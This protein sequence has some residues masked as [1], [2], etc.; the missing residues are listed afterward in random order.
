MKIIVRPV[1][2]PRR[3]TDLT[4]RLVSAIAE[5]L[6]SLQGGNRQLNWLEAECHLQW[7]GG[8]ARAEVD[9][10]TFVSLGAA[11][12]AGD[13][14]EVGAA[15]AADESGRLESQP[16]RRNGAGVERRGKAGS[17]RTGS[18]AHRLAVVGC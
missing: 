7:I 12:R 9:E 11:A 16:G 8:A 4:H 15:R 2:V 13:R 17:K 6:W 14:P 5:E 1:V 10:T 18:R 3:E